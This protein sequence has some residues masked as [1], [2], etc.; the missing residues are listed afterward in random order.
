MTFL[1]PASTQGSTLF[2]TRRLSSIPYSS[3]Y[4]LFHDAEEGI[5]PAKSFVSDIAEGDEVCHAGGEVHKWQ[6]ITV[7]VIHALTLQSL[8]QKLDVQTLTIRRSKLEGVD[9]EVIDYAIPFPPLTDIR[10]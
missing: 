2:Q 7:P 10:P 8:F 4:A 6:R 9:Y 3:V 1:V 5:D